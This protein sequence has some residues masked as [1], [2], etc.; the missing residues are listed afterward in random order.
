MNGYEDI[1]P[2]EYLTIWEAITFL[3]PNVMGL[4]IQHLLYYPSES[5]IILTTLSRI[6]AAITEDI[7]KYELGDKLKINKDLWYLHIN[8]IIL[9]KQSIIIHGL[10]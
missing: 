8:F 5:N 4:F 1:A 6:W 10:K 7:S 9:N 3:E 2:L